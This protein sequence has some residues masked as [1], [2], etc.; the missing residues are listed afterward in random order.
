MK[1]DTLEHVKRCLICQ[2]VKAERVKLPGKL[3]PLDIPEMKW[4]CISM[5]FVTGLPKVSGGFDSIFSGR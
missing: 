3:Q 1:K 4:E 5:D 2:K